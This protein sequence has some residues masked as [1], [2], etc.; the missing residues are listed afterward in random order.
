M[1]D[2]ARAL[3]QGALPRVNPAVD[4]YDAVSGGSCSPG[5]PTGP[6]WTT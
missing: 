5:T 1:R 3:R 6:R 2:S 4:S